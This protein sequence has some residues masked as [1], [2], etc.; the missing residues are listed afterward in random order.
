METTSYDLYQNNE[1]AGRIF[2]NSPNPF[3]NET[4]ISFYLPAAEHVQ[5]K[6]YTYTGKLVAQLVNKKLEKGMHTLRW[7]GLGSS[8]KNLPD[9]VYLCE[10]KTS[11]ISRSI[12]IQK[13]K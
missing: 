5:I 11:L 7:N 9:G 10:L 13:F 2:S 6:I 4:E 8:G 1:N 3:S 12:L